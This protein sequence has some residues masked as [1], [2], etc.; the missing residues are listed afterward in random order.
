[1]ATPKISVIIPVYNAAHVLNHA[2]SSILEHQDIK[3]DE[4]EIICVNDGSTD[5]SSEVL[6]QYALEFPNLTILNQE[7]KGAAAAR[8]RGIDQA[9]GQYVLFLDADDYLLPNVLGL[10]YRKANDSDLQILEFGAEG[11]SCEGRIIYRESIKGMDEV[12]TGEYYIASVPFMNSASNKLYS[13]N[14]LNVNKL[15]FPWKSVA[16]DLEFN[17]RAFFYAQKV[18]AIPD[19]CIQ[20]VHTRDSITRGDHP[21][22]QNKVMDDLLQVIIFLDD[23]VTGNY[24]VHSPAFPSLKNRIGELTYTLLYRAMRKAKSIDKQKEIV[25]KLSTKGCYP[26]KILSETRGRKLFGLIANRPYLY[27]NFCRVFNLL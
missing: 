10:V 8:N 15:R 23:F 27:F 13:L 14:F 25:A 20:F 6:E 24:T 5:S 7:N 12:V 19:I 26:V 4:L 2:L 9:H 1:M 11:V 21:E 17:I 16:E 22:K 18:S 3:M